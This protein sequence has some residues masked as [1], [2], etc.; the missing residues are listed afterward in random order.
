LESTIGTP[1]VLPRN[2]VAGEDPRVRVTRCD[3]TTAASAPSI[4]AADIDSN[5][6][7][8][9]KLSADIARLL[10]KLDEG[11]DVVSVWRKNRQ[12]KLFTRKIPS[13]IA[14]RMIS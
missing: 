3:A 7:R 6:R 5:G 4:Q 2:N 13:M 11:F 9:G 14:N 10:D 12:D 8:Y 1:N